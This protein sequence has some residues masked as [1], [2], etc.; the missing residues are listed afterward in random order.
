MSNMMYIELNKNNLHGTIPDELCALR[1]L[2]WYYLWGNNLTGSIPECIGSMVSLTSIDFGRNLLSGTLPETLCNLTLLDS[3]YLFNNNISGTIPDC[4]GEMNTLTQIEVEQNALTGTIPTSLCKLSE[5]RVFYAQDNKLHGDYPNCINN[6]TNL[7]AFGIGNNS[8]TGTVETIMSSIMRFDVSNNKLS[9]D[10]PLIP[11]SSNAQYMLLHNNEFTGRASHIFEN[12]TNMTELSHLTINNNRF[13]ENHIEN[14][15]YQLFQ[16]PQLQ[17]LSISNN[18]FHGKIPES[19]TLITQTSIQILVAHNLDIYGSLPNGLKFTNIQYL[20]MYNNRLS[21][22]LPSDFILN[23]ASLSNHTSLI[24]S[25][26]LFTCLTK[27]SVPKWLKSSNVSLIN[28]KS[29]YINQYQFVQSYV[30]T[31]CSFLCLFL[32]ISLKFKKVQQLFQINKFDKIRAND[33]YSISFDVI[34]YKI[35]CVQSILNNYAIIILII[36]LMVIYGVKSK[37]YECITIF[38]MLNVSFY[39]NDNVFINWSLIVLWIILVAVYSH[40]IFRSSSAANKCIVIN[41]FNNFKAVDDCDNEILQSRIYIK[42]FLTALMYCILFLFCIFLTGMYIIS[43]SLPTENTLNLNEFD[44]L[45][46]QRSMAY[47]LTFNNSLIVPK[48]IDNSYKLMLRRKSLSEQFIIKWRTIIIFLLRTLTG[49]IIPCVLSVILLNDCGHGW[50]ILWNECS[51]NNKHK[52]DIKVP[53]E[54]M[55]TGNGSLNPSLILSTSNEICGFQPIIWN[56]C[57]RQFLNSWSQIIVK[58]L[59]LMV[60]MPFIITAYKILYKD[61]LLK[62]CKNSRGSKHIKIDMEYS[63]IATKIE[64]MIIFSFVTP[65][66][67]PITLLSINTNLF[68]FKYLVKYKKWD[69]YP[70]RSSAILVPINMTV[71]AII[72]SQIFI[73]I[74]TKFAIQNYALT[75]FLIG[76]LIVIDTY[77]IALGCK[78]AN[79]KGAN[80]K[81]NSLLTSYAGIPSI[82]SVSKR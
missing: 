38:D 72:V 57:V 11:S 64:L 18:D 75:I 22:S 36:F 35:F 44:I 19:K 82:N 53:L 62:F 27:K 30:L 7:W 78:I 81:N 12:V 15:L 34:F 5:L 25:S 74:F 76:S 29:I 77:Y 6:L 52:F 55:Y 33:A 46:I 4:F 16:L 50:T 71:I 80:E 45:L 20:T 48:L 31:I 67:V 28:A 61:F 37:Y 65:I 24:L 13:Q 21:C 10:F 68:I 2:G 59:L 41:D 58:K 8:I 54:G 14:I 43:E 73:V 17:I 51:T 39:L 1:N 69:V 63:M 42:H 66:V 49:V 47:V 79:K 60:I 70:Y 3:L 9:G 23:N 56:K 40:I 26:N 32:M